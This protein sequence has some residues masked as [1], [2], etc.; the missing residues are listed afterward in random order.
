MNVSEAKELIARHEW[1]TERAQNLRYALRTLSPDNEYAATARCRL[2]V[3]QGTRE[4]IVHLDVSKD[5]AR[6]LFEAELAKVEREQSQI[7]QRL[8]AV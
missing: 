2:A 4:W 5:L 8:A 6:P 7:E 3:Q 1:N